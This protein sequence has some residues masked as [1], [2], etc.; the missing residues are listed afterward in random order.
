MMLAV[1]ELSLANNRILE[2]AIEAKYTQRVVVITDTQQKEL[3]NRHQF[4]GKKVDGE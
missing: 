3:M 1:K 4:A 2:K